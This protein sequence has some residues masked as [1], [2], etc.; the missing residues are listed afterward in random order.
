MAL[1]YSN[2]PQLGS[3][4]PFFSLLCATSGKKITRDDFSDQKILTVIFMCNHCPYVKAVRSRIN[5]IAQQYK[6]QNVA[7]VGINSNDAENYPEDNF[8]AMKVESFQQG[9]TF[10]YLYDETQNVAKAYKAQCTPDPY[11]YENVDGKFLL[12]YQGQIDDNWKEEDQVKSHDLADAVE[13]IL[14][15]QPVSTNQKPSMGCNIKW[16]QN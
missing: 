11:V 8:E 2:G 7:L 3:E 9:Y 13:S 16:K 6:S 14:S 4:A 15:G 5:V 12:R 10:H 1:T